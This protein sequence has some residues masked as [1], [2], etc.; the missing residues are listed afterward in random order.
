MKYTY[1]RF[2]FPGSVRLHHLSHYD[3][4]VPGGEIST[5]SP[6]SL[7][8]E[9]CSGSCYQHL[10]RWIW[11]SFSTFVTVLLTYMS[12]SSDHTARIS[13]ITL[14][15]DYF[16][17]TQFLCVLDHRRWSTPDL[18]VSATVF[19]TDQICFSQRCHDCQEIICCGVY[20]LLLLVPCGCH[21]TDG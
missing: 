20:R 16:P 11:H 19:Q 17:D 14:R 1:C 15:F 10:D 2:G 8:L 13:R 7:F 4:S 21:G 6:S 5:A 3:R 9:I 12:S 18:S